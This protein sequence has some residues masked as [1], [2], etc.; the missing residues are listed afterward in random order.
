MQTCQEPPQDF[1]PCL[2]GNYFTENGLR[3][4]SA[5]SGL[6]TLWQQFLEKDWPHENKPISIW[7]K[8]SMGS[9]PRAG[10]LE[11]HELQDPFQPEPLY[12]CMKWQFDSP[13]C[14]AKPRGQTQLGLQLQEREAVWPDPRVQPHPSRDNSG[15][16]DIPPCPARGQ[17][18]C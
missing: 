9:M 6:Q 15:R 17:A 8:G 10:G 4:M 5:F 11:P 13:L 14:T 12:D 3:G 18:A 1:P 2:V 7:E 16:K